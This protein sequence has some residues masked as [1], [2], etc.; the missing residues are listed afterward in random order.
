MNLDSYKDDCPNAERLASWLG[1]GASQESEIATHVDVCSKCQASLNE[2]TESDVV[3]CYRKAAESNWF[4]QTVLGKHLDLHELGSFGQYTV[5]ESIGSG[6]MG[7]VYRAKDNQLDREVAIK[8]LTNVFSETALARFEREARTQSKLDHPNIVS[9]YGSGT[10]ERGIPFLVMPFVEGISLKSLIDAESMKIPEAVEYV[11]Q[12]ATGLHAAHQMGLVHRD[13][14]PLNILISKQDRIAR[15]FD[16]GLVR[17]KDEATLTRTEI[18]CGTPE[19]MSPEQASNIE[20]TDARGDIY[21]LGVTLYEC[22]TG[23][24]PFRGRPLDVLSQHRQLEPL[25]PAQLNQQIKADLDTI[26][27]KALQKE[28]RH[29]YQTA[30]D[31]AD[32]LQ[33]WLDKKPI[34]ARPVGHVEKGLR[35]ASRNRGIAISLSALFI[36]L[37]ASSV[38]STILWRQSAF[39]EKRAIESNRSLQENQ[40]VLRHNQSEL[41]EALR[42]SYLTTIDS[43]QSYLMDLPIDVRNTILIEITQ[44]WTLLFER[45]KND[46]DD[47]RKMIGELNQATEFALQNYMYLRANEIATLNRKVVDHFL[48]LTGNSDFVDLVLVAKSFNLYSE[49]RLSSPSPKPEKSCKR[50]IRFA[51]LALDRIKSDSHPNE[52]VL[53]TLQAISGERLYIK[54]SASEEPAAASRN[55]RKLLDRIADLPQVDDYEGDRLFL[56]Q[57][58][59]TDLSRVDRESAIAHMSNCSNTLEKLLAWQ[60]DRNLRSE[61]TLRALAVNSALLGV[62]WSRKGEAVEA[63]KNW[64][65]GAT[66]IEELISFN[67]LNVQ[68]RADLYEINLLVANF[69]WGQGNQS[70]SIIAFE[71]TAENARLS[72]RVNRGDYKQIQRVARVFHSI[73]QKYLKANQP[74]RAA[75]LCEEAAGILGDKLDSIDMLR[76]VSIEPDIQFTSSLLDAAASGYEKAGLLNDKKRVETKIEQFRKKYEVSEALNTESR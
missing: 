69:E 9:V 43:E 7:V 17:S 5:I 35:W 68:Y 70:E 73:G 25:P 6:G 72:L 55:I 52:F 74:A 24:V 54:C 60:T 50:A 37:L 30:A 51:N 14:K 62:E 16:F 21:S 66:R 65:E 33:N 56:H 32:D 39:N 59:F 11:R 61:M 63:R 28:P 67:P 45:A 71:E 38:I 31:F 57:Q 22:L 1:E 49:A 19:Y 10:T 47:L 46:P 4:R 76:N 75:K 8:V 3:N 2:L 12:A 40:D 36:V 27:M 29:R 15:L 34:T 20:G 53:A 42:N 18:L 44:A 41:S 26:C 64:H 58:L 13:V 23:T 48:D